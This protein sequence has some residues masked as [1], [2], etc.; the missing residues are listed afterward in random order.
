VDPAA[1]DGKRDDEAAGET[2][3]PDP[4]S[5]SGPSPDVAT[6]AKPIPPGRTNDSAT[7]LPGRTVGRKPGAYGLAIDFES[8]E[9]DP[10]IARLV[11]S[12]VYVNEAH[13]AW[14]RALLTRSDGYHIALS[15]AMA[16]A[17]LAAAPDAAHDFITTFLERWGRA[18]ETPA[19]PKRRRR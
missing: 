1:T 17:P 19:G 16:L 18:A 13:P 7:P 15:V 8:R 5:P 4:A 12:S 3:P 11:E 10:R 9:G 2:P 6:N 14:R